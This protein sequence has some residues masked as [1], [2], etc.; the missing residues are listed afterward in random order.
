MA[1]MNPPNA[2]LGSVTSHRHYDVIMTN[3][4]LDGGSSPMRVGDGDKAPGIGGGQLSSCCY[5]AVVF[6]SLYRTPSRSQRWS[7]SQNKVYTAAGER[8]SRREFKWTCHHTDFRRLS[9]A[10]SVMCH[11][12]PARCLFPLPEITGLP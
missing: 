1:K 4:R 5:A 7:R 10:C 6:F 3:K 12:T 2:F 11:G 8:R 9:A